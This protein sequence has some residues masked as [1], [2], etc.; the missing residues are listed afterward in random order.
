M[1]KWVG[2]P[3]SVVYQLSLKGRWTKT[4]RGENKG[5]SSRDLL[6]H[7]TL[8]WMW[9]LMPVIQKAKEKGLL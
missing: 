9:W 5:A 8:S 1:G 4:H 6:N 7:P 2:D 3:W